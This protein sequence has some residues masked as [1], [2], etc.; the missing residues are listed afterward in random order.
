MVLHTMRKGVQTMIQTYVRDTDL[1]SRYSISRSTVW[2]WVHRGLLPAPIQ[3]SAGVTRWQLDA[4]ERR[5]AERGS[6]IP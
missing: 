5:D 6:Q 2:R 4:I 1:A 3:L